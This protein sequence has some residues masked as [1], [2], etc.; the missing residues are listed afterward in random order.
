MARYIIDIEDDTKDGLYKAKNFNTLVFDKE[1]L[2]RLDPYED[3]K[4]PEEI[5]PWRAD[6]GGYYYAIC[7]TLQVRLFE[8]KQSSSDD[9]RYTIGNYYKIHEEAEKAAERLKVYVELKRFAVPDD[10]QNWHENKYYYC[11]M[12]NMYENNLI[13][14]IESKIFKECG[15]YFATEEQVQK[16]IDAV[17][18]D[19][20]K[21][22]YFG[23]ED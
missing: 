8:D 9:A 14:G 10:E 12:Y 5:K 1:G 18:A 3:P 19:R 15:L 16:A 17:G 23:I 11:P 22:Y 20:I 21:R 6:R 7:S 4:K 13:V 2:D